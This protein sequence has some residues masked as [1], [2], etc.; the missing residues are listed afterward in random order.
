[1]K[2]GDHFPPGRPPRLRGFAFAVESATRRL[3]AS[4]S[5]SPCTLS[6]SVSGTAGAN[7]CFTCF[8][9][10]AHSM[11]KDITVMVDI[12]QHPYR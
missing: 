11:I 10:M 12:T 6:D 1:L 8:F 3:L 2:L 5:L 7:R 4:A 9:A